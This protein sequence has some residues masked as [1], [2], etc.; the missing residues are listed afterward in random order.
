MAYI[1]TPVLTLKDLNLS[2]AF[3]NEEVAVDKQTAI[4]EGMFL[5]ELC[6]CGISVVEI[7]EI[8]NKSYN[9]KFGSLT[10]N[11]SKC[12]GIE[13]RFFSNIIN[14]EKILSKDNFSDFNRD[15]LCNILMYLT[16]ARIN[17]DVVENE[18]TNLFKNN[19]DKK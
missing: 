8:D 13:S 17:K 10:I 14:N 12:S 2:E 3:T 5:W 4:I 16:T 18:L 6:K 15:K 1:N 19:K 7:S 9:K 11:Y